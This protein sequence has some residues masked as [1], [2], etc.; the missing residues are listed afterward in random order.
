[1]GERAERDPAAPLRLVV[2]R[3]LVRFVL[4]RLLHLDLAPALA[5]CFGLDFRLPAEAERQRQRDRRADPGRNADDQ[6]REA[7]HVIAGDP[8][9]QAQQRIAGDAAETG[10]QRPGRG[11][12]QAG[13][14]ARGEHDRQHPGEQA[15]PLPMQ[16]AMACQAPAPD[17]DR[18]HERHRGDAEQLHRQVGDDGATEAEQVAHRRVGGVAERGILCRPRRQR[19][20]QQHRDCDQRNAG[21][22]AH[23]LA[24]CVAQAVG[25]TE[26]F[27][28]AVDSRH[29]AILNPVSRPGGAAP[30]PWCRG[31]VRWRRGYIPHPG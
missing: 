4:L 3:F 18:H 8:H 1:M 21:Q 22:L 12:R 14:E 5:R 20:D 10:G 13:G 25:E 9:R 30:R 19:G 15:Q 29:G 24:Q 2:R 17:R 26:A 7:E 6:P 28:S 27:E 31:P 16:R 11:A 23:A